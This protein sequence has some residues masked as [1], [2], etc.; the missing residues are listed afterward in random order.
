[1]DFKLIIL[2]LMDIYVSVALI[3]LIAGFH[4][5]LGMLLLC[6]VFLVFK[7]LLGAMSGGGLMDLGVLL[8]VVFSIFSTPPIILLV[9]GAVL[10]GQKGLVSIIH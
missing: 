5:P 3:S 8:L 9:I 1:M 2:G 6:A 4:V 7:F 10:S